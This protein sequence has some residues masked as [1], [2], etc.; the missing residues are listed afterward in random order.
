M[1]YKEERAIA[2]NLRHNL[3]SKVRQII[4]DKEGYDN[5]KISQ[6]LRFLESKLSAREV[7]ASKTFLYQAN[8]IIHE[9]EKNIGGE[10]SRLKMES[11]YKIINDAIDRIILR[12]KSGGNKIRWSATTWFFIIAFALLIFNSYRGNQ[13]GVRIVTKILFLVGGGILLFNLFGKRK[14]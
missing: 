6:K 1:D 9:D 11:N 2:V 10:Y 14:D 13:E 7:S 4:P 12:E 8:L 3:E 5:N